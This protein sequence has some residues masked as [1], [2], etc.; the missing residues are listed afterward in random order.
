[1]RRHTFIHLLCHACLLFFLLLTACKRSLSPVM[2]PILMYT[3]D[4]AIVLKGAADTSVTPVTAWNGSKGSFAFAVTPVPGISIDNGT[5]KISWTPAVP[6]GT[7][8]L[9]VIARNAASTADTVFY[10]LTV[11]GPITT[12]A[13]NI[14]GFAGDG[15]P[16]V[17]ASLDNPSDVTLDAQNNIYIADTYNNRIRVINPDGT[18]HPFAGDGNSAFAGDGGPA[19]AAE[20]ESPYAISN[21]NAGNFYITDYGNSRI[22][23]INANGIISTIAGTTYTTP[24]YLG[25]GG[26]ATQAQLYLIGGKVALDGQGDL[27]IG[28]YGDQRV[29]EVTPDGIIHT[30][31]GTGSSGSF[32]P[33]GTPALNAG[34]ANPNGIYTG[35]DGNIYI[36]S[37]V[38]STIYRLN[39]GNIYNVA[40]SPNAWANWGQSGDGGP[41]QKALFN[42]PTNIVADNQGNLFIADFANNKIREID[43]K[44]IITTVAGNG[45]S[46][47]SGDGGPA[48]AAELSGPYGLAVDANGNLY[49]ADTF[50][51]RIRKVILH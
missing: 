51:N 5:G 27:Y 33:D 6:I 1:M 39:A 36:V 11:S 22:R 47:F 19:A 10:T 35:A 38:G 23:K 8:L 12:I 25:D 15:G 50:N 32:I 24:G 41:A 31:A 20:F 21:D 29:R 3:P 43:T 2:P 40:G 13:G 26:P 18:I 49:I 28:D 45:Q 7:Y 16:A 17:N 9:P 34:I 14:R 42:R 46:G 37:E 4:T 30:I 48:A 44:G